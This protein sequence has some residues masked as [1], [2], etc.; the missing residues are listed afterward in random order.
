[1]KILLKSRQLCT[2]LYADAYHCLY[3]Q[4]AVTTTIPQGN[5]LPYDHLY[6][7]ILC[8]KKAKYKCSYVVVYVTPEPFDSSK[9]ELGL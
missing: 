8:Q 2:K 9:N 1:M 7:K 4:H 3:N 6:P 5:N